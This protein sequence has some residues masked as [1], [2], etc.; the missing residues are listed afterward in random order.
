MIPRD[1]AFVDDL[2]ALQAK[3]RA[4]GALESAPYFV[5]SDFLIIAAI[6]FGSWRF[7]AHHPALGGAAFGLVVHQTFAHAHTFGHDAGLFERER[8]QIPALHTAFGYAM[9]ISI[10]GIDAVAWRH[11]HQM[12]HGYTMADADPQI[13]NGN[14]FPLFSKNATAIAE[15]IAKKPVEGLLLRWQEVTWLPVLL[16]VEKHYLWMENWRDITKL[17]AR[18]I[19]DSDVCVRRLF[20]CGHYA[21]LWLFMRRLRH[22][23]GGRRRRWPLGGYARWLVA[24][25]VFSGIIGPQFLFNHVDTGR[26]PHGM[27]ND[28]RAQILHTVNYACRLPFQME[29]WLHVGLAHQIEHHLAPKVLPE[30]LPS[31]SADVQEL[32]RNH[33]LPYRS[34]GLEH[35]LWKHTRMLANVSHERRHGQWE[36][37]DKHLALLLAALLAMGLWWLFAVPA[38]RGKITPMGAAE[39]SPGSATG[40]SAVHG[41]MAA[42]ADGSGAIAEEARAGSSFLHRKSTKV[43]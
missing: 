31:I 27:L 40:S 25:S 18:G 7:S 38:G 8:W 17:A 14:Y 23:G 13:R 30:W 9:T 32:C 1:D 35:L 11:N 3:W 10:C 33:S 16:L 43:S 22:S 24:Y 39:V 37:A 42:S 12:H 34:E 41:Q 15:R 5:I 19:G 26:E 28:K 36:T 2:A 4:S 20:L 21:L 29:E 6:S